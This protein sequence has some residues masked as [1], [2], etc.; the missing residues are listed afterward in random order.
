MAECEKLVMC[1]FFSGKMK[2]MPNTATLLK[3][4][5]CLGDKTRCARYRVSMAGIPVP[6]DLFPNDSERVQQ[7]LGMRS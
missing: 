7:I 3:E 1:P 2:A 4:T 6:P 5:S